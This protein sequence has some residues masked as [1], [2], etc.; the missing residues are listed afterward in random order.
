MLNVVD[1]T[2]S[3]LEIKLRQTLVNPVSALFFAVQKFP[4]HLVSPDKL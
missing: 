4:Q 1:H 3:F 2:H